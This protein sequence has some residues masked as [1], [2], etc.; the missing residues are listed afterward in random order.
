VKD[1]DTL[2]Q[3]KSLEGGEVTLADLS[4]KKPKK[5]KKEKAPKE[6]K[7]KKD[8]KTIFTEHIALVTPESLKK[9]WMAEK[10]FRLITDAS[11]LR[12]WAE[13]ILADTSRHH[14]FHDTICPVIAVDTETNGLDTRVVNG[15]VGIE[16]AGICLS[17][18]GIE[19]IYIPVGHEQGPNIDRAELVRVLQDLFDKSH[20]VFFNA[21]FDREVLRITLGMTFRDYPHYE[22]LQVLSYLEDPKASVDSGAKGGGQLQTGGLKYFAKTRLGIEQIELGDFA[23]VKA[24]VWNEELQKD[25]IKT[26]MAPFTW[27]PIELA[28]WYAAGDA[29]TTWLGWN[30]VKD[31]ARAMAAVHRVDHLLID[32]LTWIERQRV[33]I[34]VDLLRATIEFHAS[35]VAQLTVELAELAG[36][37]DFNPGSPK[38]LSEVLFKKRGMTPL[39]VSEK[40]GE[41]ST[42]IGVLTELKKL[43]PDDDFLNKLIDFREYSALHPGNLRYDP[44]D[45]SARFYFKQNVV[46][47]G[48]LAA[49]GGDYEKDGGC[50][51]NVQAIKKIGGNWWVKGKR[52]ED[53]NVDIETL[54]KYQP[55]DLDPSCFNKDKALAPNIHNNHI[56]VYFGKKYCVV[57]ACKTCIGSK[58]K[59]D[60]NEIINL[61][62]LFCAKPGWT[63]FTTDYSNIEMRVAANCSKEP[64]FIEEF[65][66]GSGDFHSLTASALFPEFTDPTVDK[67]RK[68]AL[69]S[70]AKIINFALLYG[71]TAYTIYENMVKEGH[72]VTFEDAQDLVAKYWDSVPVF[73]AFC[74]SKRELARTKL[75]CKTPTGRIISF[76]SAMKG[77]NIYHPLPKHKDNFFTWKK[78]SK[79]ADNF[80]KSNQKEEF[81][82]TKAQADA[83]YNNRESGVKNFTEYNRF[84]GK[85]ERVSINIPLQGTAGDL[86]R[87][88]LNKIRIWATSTPGVE[89]VFKLHCTVH[90]EID[91]SVKNEFV[92]Y[93]VPRLNK[94]MKLRKLHE[95]KDWPVPIETDCEY[96][97]SWD[98]DYHLTGDSDHKAAGWYD[99][100]GMQNYIP[101][102]FDA[103]LVDKLIRS[104]E[105]GKE[106]KVVSWLTENLHT[107]VHPILKSLKES[108]D[109]E[110]RKRYI[111]VMLQLDEFWRLDEDEEDALN[112]SVAEYASAYGFEIPVTPI[113][114]SQPI[115]EEVQV[116]EPEEEEEKEVIAQV[117]AEED[118]DEDDVFYAPKKKEKKEEP[119]P[120]PTPEAVVEAKSVIPVT[121]VHDPVIQNLRALT[122]LEMD[123]FIAVLGIGN[124]TVTFQYKG[125]VMKV[126]KVAISTLPREYTL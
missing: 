28:L 42:A 18:D 93:I 105:A 109:T 114:T 89:E 57:P 38:Q 99:V 75:I 126:S 64:R 82:A 83:I 48:R 26:V 12:K 97:Q 122:N 32:T 78:L 25:T 61:R 86:M 21:K 15:K 116:N 20:L 72:D 88:A 63:Y 68:K 4:E 23:K 120:E 81:L 41:A 104:L 22:D 90:D 30:L 49:A 10:S 66:T 45:N 17:A 94:F 2:E 47:G 13:G 62:S 19:G 111:T 3:L 113:Y 110:G 100:P 121:Q 91:F 59:V 51:L 76:E 9:P 43:Y 6:P 124:K 71:G 103:D 74:N 55:S 27:V 84:L 60:A 96:G 46:A 69:R 54:E 119:A 123:A 107:R 5:A 50:G 67:G 39:A 44:R 73:S 29:I 79:Q 24:K 101:R 112:E 98:V 95:A 7:V 53:Q 117:Q 106:E 58:S 11:E 56:A 33:N 14:K 31:K 115:T 65:M 108:T 34:D 85:A 1:D 16:L 40:S 35:R 70:L 80:K 36:I 37:P 77:F 102:G 8:L 52:L 118:F 125:K 92:P 87:S